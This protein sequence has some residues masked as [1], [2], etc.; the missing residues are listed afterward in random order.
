MPCNELKLLESIVE[1]DCLKIL[2]Y[3][4]TASSTNGCH[5]S[6]TFQLK[7]DMLFDLMYS[8]DLTLT[9]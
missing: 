8:V 6:G 2:S 5:D 4:L 1:V 3:I 9:I 7:F